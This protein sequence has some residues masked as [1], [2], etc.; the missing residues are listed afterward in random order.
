[1]SVW[2]VP[3]FAGRIWGPFTAGVNVEVGVD[4]DADVG[5]D[6][7]VDVDV[8]VEDVDVDVDVILSS[9]ELASSGL[10]VLRVSSL[11]FLSLFTSPSSSPAGL[12]SSQSSRG[13]LASC[14]LPI[15]TCSPSSCPGSL[16]MVSSVSSP[17]LASSGS[18]G[19]FWGSRTAAISVGLGWA[20]KCHPC[21]H[22]HA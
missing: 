7:D 5:V 18:A 9:S 20:Y 15:S 4:V 1:M 6:V 21:A 2:Y 14:R 3:G 22:V 8:G 12:S 19:L 10:F 13:L 11:S 16:L 17:V